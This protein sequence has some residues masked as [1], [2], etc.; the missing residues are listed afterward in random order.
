MTAS[1]AA[2][3]R[4]PVKG[5]S[6][7]RLGAVA[8]TP[9]EGLP[10]DRL[11]ALALADTEFDAAAPRHLPKTRFL[12]LLRHE[13][14]AALKTRLETEGGVRRVVIR[15][16]D[17]QLLLDQPID[18][19]AGRQAVAAFFAGCFPDYCAAGSPRLVEAPGHMFSDVPAKVVSLINLGSVAALGA[20]VGATLDPLR[21][22][23]NVHLAGVEPWAEFGWVG[24]EVAIG[25]V[26]LKVTQRIRRCAATDVD[27]E[28]G[29]RDQKLP[30]T[31][32]AGF[33]HGDL[34]V[35][36]EVL[37]SGSLT[38]GDQVTLG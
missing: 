36:A 29:A 6:P 2:L 11:L 8:V 31:L 25:G 7:E 28:T 22:R 24:R 20:A 4:Y 5:L 33:G 18:D 17:G 23:G 37:T 9:G 38:E 35:Y 12:V 30:P 26:R 15:N 21:F 14:L 3:Y 19:A 13:R 34:G 27:P 1:V 10:G 16:R 32:L